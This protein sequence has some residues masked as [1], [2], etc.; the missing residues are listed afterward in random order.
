M[1]INLWNSDHKYDVRFEGI[2]IS[3]KNYQLDFFFDFYCMFNNNELY[4]NC[5]YSFVQRYKDPRFFISQ[6]CQCNS[7][8]IDQHIHF[9]QTEVIKERSSN[10]LWSLTIIDFYVKNTL[11]TIYAHAHRFNM[12]SFFFILKFIFIFLNNLFHSPWKQR[13][14]YKL[15]MQ[16]KW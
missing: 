15:Q 6:N 14:H 10:V 1:L 4:L 8:Y 3:S 11:H 2:N 13:N 9:D 7:K 12:K 5:C 16:S